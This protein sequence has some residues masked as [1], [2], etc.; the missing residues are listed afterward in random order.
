M[1]YLDEELAD[2]RGGEVDAQA[3]RV[4]PIEDQFMYALHLAQLLR[5]RLEPSL[6][7][8]D[9]GVWTKIVQQQSSQ[10]DADVDSSRDEVTLESISFGRGYTFPERCN[11]REHADAFLD[12]GL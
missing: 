9:I 4:T 3:P 6:G 5:P 8:E 11:G 7:P 12:A 2:H 1:I 10:I